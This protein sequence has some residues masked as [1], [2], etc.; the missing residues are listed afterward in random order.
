MSTTTV[1]V[2]KAEVKRL[3]APDVFALSSQETMKS[4]TA[5]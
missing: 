2:L 5:F 3:E 4:A 1:A